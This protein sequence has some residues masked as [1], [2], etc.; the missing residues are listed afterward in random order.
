[1]E[2][3]YKT[4]TRKRLLGA[5]VRVVRAGMPPGGVRRQAARGG[6]QAGGGGRRRAA[7]HHAGTPVR[8]L[9]HPARVREPSLTASY[10]PMKR[11]REDRGKDA[12]HRITWDEAIDEIVGAHRRAAGEIRPRDGGGVRRHG[13]RGNAVRPRVRL[14]G[15]PHA[16]PRVRHER[17]GVLR[18]AQHDGGQ[19]LRHHRL[20]GNRHS[21]VVA[22]ALRRP[23]LHAARAGG[24]LGQGP[25]AVEPRRLLRPRGHRHDEARRAVH[26]GGPARHVAGLALRDGAA[27]APRHR[28][29]P[30]HGR[31]A[32]S[33]STR[34][35]TTRTWWRSGCTASKTSPNACA[36]CR[37]SARPRSAGWR[38][39]TSTPSP[40][41]TPRPSRRPSPGAWRSTSSSRARRPACASWP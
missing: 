28:R 37:R 26:H 4:G 16:L 25:A 35:C 29:R 20:P 7:S 41:A 22:Q 24:V 39:R 31:A 2:Q 15:V 14:G 8:A 17:A 18:A 27:G 21:R 6:R 32:T 11:A 23:G 9:L 40:A 36:R 38:W 3:A 5:V 19:H 12:W 13:T 34:N 33:S 10:Y 30:C 1:M